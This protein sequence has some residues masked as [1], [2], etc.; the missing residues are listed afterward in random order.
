VYGYPAGLA[1]AI[2]VSSVAKA[3]PRH[4]VIEKVLFF[5]FSRADLQ[6]YQ[7]LL[8]SEGER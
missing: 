5:C 3:L 8:Q 7:Q 2:A 1:S 6:I 4:G